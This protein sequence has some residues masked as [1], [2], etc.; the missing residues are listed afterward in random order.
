MSNN[1][2]EKRARINYIRTPDDDAQTWSMTGHTAEE[3]ISWLDSGSRLYST[4]LAEDPV[5]H[6]ILHN[7]AP[8]IGTC[9]E[10]FEAFQ[11]KQWG[12]KVYN[13][14]GS[15]IEVSNV[16]VDSLD[17]EPASHPSASEYDWSGNLNV[18]CNNFYP[19]RK[20]G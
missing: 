9:L 10:D 7:T 20:E 18:T 5:F 6:S 16:I 4:L 15:G 17:S 3:I 1:P 19:V 12:L 13:L 8:T 2:N 11:H 14:T